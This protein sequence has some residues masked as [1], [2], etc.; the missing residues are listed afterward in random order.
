M[1]QVGGSTTQPAARPAPIYRDFILLQLAA[2]VFLLDQLTKYAV[3][4]FIPFR[5]SFPEDGF[6]RITHTFNT[7]SAFGMFQGQN[8]PLIFVSVVGIAVLVLVYR[9]QPQ[10]TSLL[11]LSLG[12]Q[13]GGAAGNLL[14]RLRL[15]HVTDFIDVG[16]WPVFNL[17]DSS[18]VIGLLLLA[19]L[20]LRSGGAARRTPVPATP[21]ASTATAPAEAT[22]GVAPA[23]PSGDK[24]V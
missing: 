6:F 11:R 8:T 18:I 15:G 23:E 17:A 3:R 13:I 14:D 10:V 5:N 16:P 19:W 12:M 1:A 9:S 7:G 2:L 20:L 24:T 4:A 22:L 21:A